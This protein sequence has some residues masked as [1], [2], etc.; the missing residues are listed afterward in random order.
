M[1]YKLGQLLEYHSAT[2]ATWIPCVVT[3][4]NHGTAAVQINVKT[5]YWM[6]QS[7]QSAKLRNPNASRSAFQMGECLQ[8]LSRSNK[9]WMACKVIELRPSDGAL[10]I[11]VKPGHWFS[12]E[13]QTRFF[14]KPSDIQMM[15][16]TDKPIELVQAP[17]AAARRCH[18]LIVWSDYNWHPISA[19]LGGPS[20]RGLDTEQ[21]A[22][23]F[24]NLLLRY[25]ITGFTELARKDCTKRKLLNAILHIGSQCEKE[26]QFIL[27]YTGHGSTI[28]DQDGDEDNGFD[29][30]MVLLDE[31][32]QRRDDLRDDDLA[33]WLVN[34]V[35][36]DH[37]LL[38]FD[39][40]HSATLADL[41]KP[42]WSGKHA[43]S[44]SGCEDE[45][46]SLGTGKGGVFTHA[47]VQ[48]TNGLAGKTQNPS[49]A[50]FYND[51][52]L[53]ANEIKKT[54]GK[55]EFKQKVSIQ[56][57]PGVDPNLVGWPFTSDGSSQ[58]GS[59]GYA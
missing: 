12:L 58:K 51:V 39:C 42:M 49:V 52:L 30:T 21:G 48:A 37:L 44:L 5:G 56:C 25:G 36:A 33:L 31:T 17:V 54:M 16:L 7:E 55:G 23:A 22:T 45:E 4:V 32:G 28:Q 27:Y 43:I 59:G 18:V 3:G 41:D 13:S 26:D 15:T 46:S 38:L 6:E 1:V 50:E 34:H 8:Y 40:C 57:S 24:K 47:L 9:K 35:R 53:H 2:E 20:G 14:R 19:S 11:D 10:Q 29:E